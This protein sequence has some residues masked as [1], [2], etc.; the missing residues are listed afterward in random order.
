MN[1]TTHP[2]RALS[3]AAEPKA[4][5]PLSWLWPGVGALLCSGVAVAALPRSSDAGAR[6]V[7]WQALA[8]APLARGGNTGLRMDPTGKVAPIAV[9]PE[10]QRLDF[11]L[12]SSGEATGALLMRTGASYADAAQAASMIGAIPAGTKVRLLLGER[13]GSG[14][15]IV[16]VELTPRMDLKLKITRTDGTLFLSREQLAVDMT[17]LRI[18]GRAGDGLYWALRSAGATPVAAAEY[19]RAL[20]GQIDVGAD[21]G[22]NDSFDLVVA[23]RKGPNGERQMGPLLYAGI[24]RLGAR[25]IE[26]VRWTTGGRTQWVDAASLDQP[27]QQQS[28]GMAWPTAGR[29]TSTFGLRYHPILHFARMHK[30]IDIG[31]AW[32][33]PIVAAASGQ[34]TAAG[35]AGGS[36]RQVRIS[37]GGGIATSYSHMSSIVAQPGSFVQ[38]GQLIGYVGSSGLSTGAHLHYEVYMSG[39]PVNPLTV[40]FASAMP[41]ANNDAKAIRARLKALLSVGMRHS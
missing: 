6:D 12:T 8:I 32:G 34:V 15:A 33:S 28:A 27:Q 36:G 31:A 40:R 1:R 39:T 11:S 30:G 3:L 20:A 2:L 21:V 10:R 23:S 24:S 7:Q 35:W 5:K 18:R 4:P 16:R 13:S 38:Q 29:I 26:L 9:A 22:A 14:R 37:H 19:L 41:I 25:P 17:P